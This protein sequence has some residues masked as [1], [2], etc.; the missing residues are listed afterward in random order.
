MHY[1]QYYDSPLGRILLSGD[2]ETINGLWFSGQ[3]YYA[4]TLAPDHEE[5]ETDALAQAKRWLDVYFSGKKPDFT[6]PLSMAATEFRK[7]VWEIL[8]TIPYGQT[9]EY[10]QIAKQI[11]ESRNGV[12]TSARA[13]GAAVGHNPISLIIP[14][15][16]V[17]GADGSLTG[18]AGGTDK[19]ERL[20]AMEGYYY[21]QPQKRM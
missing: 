14:C 2:K 18:Y 10:G 21:R 5:G 6:P 20:L 19:K 13:V 9:M 15:H 8:L 16:R 17:I 7:T 11:T 4:S 12:R 1:I 3:K